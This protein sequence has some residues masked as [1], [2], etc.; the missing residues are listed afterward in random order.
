MFEVCFVFFFEGKR[1]E[2]ANF[3]SSAEGK[4]GIILHANVPA[5]R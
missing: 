2:K 3:S 5:S 1:K 4:R